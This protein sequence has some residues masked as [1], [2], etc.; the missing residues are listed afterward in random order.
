MK[1]TPA[2]S[3]LFGEDSELIKS[4]FECFVGTLAEKHQ[5]QPEVFATYLG[6]FELF[7]MTRGGSCDLSPLEAAVDTLV[8]WFDSLDKP[9]AKNI[10]IKADENLREGND[11]FWSMLNSN[12]KTRENFSFK[13]NTDKL[14]EAINSILEFIVGREGWLISAFQRNAV[15]VGDEVGLHLLLDGCRVFL[16]R[17]NNLAVTDENLFGIP[18][19]QWRNIAAHKS[20]RCRGGKVNASFG[21]SGAKVV[22][23]SR[24]ELERAIL[25]IYKFRIGIKLVTGLALSI[26]AAKNL[27]FIEATQFS[28]R[29]FLHDLN[30]LLEKHGV[31]LESFELLN[32]LV[33]EG[34]KVDV[35]HDF[36]IFDV[37]FSCHD[38][39]ETDEAHLA[40]F[41]ARIAKVLEHIFGEH[42]TLPEKE[43]VLLHF[44]RSPDNGF[45]MIYTYD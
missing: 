25:E 20:Y 40:S 8:E 23:I 38:Y 43:K 24:D 17:G 35:P 30:Y 41:V 28:P 44:S 9:V 22:T 4:Y 19:N 11:A 39:E 21:R 1:V 45:H 3:S 15:D 29:S 14:F 34:N 7:L 5:I 6:T 42:N 26:V 27:D 36:S 10:F 12:P 18:L 33:L 32:E 13:E 37:K 2:N 31:Q 16:S